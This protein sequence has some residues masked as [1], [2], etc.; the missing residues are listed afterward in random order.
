[1]QDLW[2]VSPDYAA[3]ETG[4]WASITIAASLDA[5]AFYGAGL[6]ACNVIHGHSAQSAAK[7]RDAQGLRKAQDYF[8]RFAQSLDFAP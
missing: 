4:S 7:L 1:M 6:P 8:L 2:R 3:L 5:L